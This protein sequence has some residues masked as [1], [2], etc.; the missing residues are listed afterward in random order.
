MP[1]D[2][3]RTGHEPGSNR[4]HGVDEVVEPADVAA[5]VHPHE[6]G[7]VSGREVAGGPQAGTF[8]IRPVHTA[9]TGGGATRTELADRTR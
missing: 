3:S 6:A 5:L 1:G 8:G 2:L 7:A 9:G 4:Q